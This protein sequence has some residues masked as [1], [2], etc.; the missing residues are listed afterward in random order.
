VPSP[1]QTET[2][3]LSRQLEPAGDEEAAPPQAIAC[4]YKE[5]GV[6]RGDRGEGAAAEARKRQRR[7][8]T[9]GADHDQSARIPQ[10][11][12]EVEARPHHRCRRRS[13]RAEDV[14]ERV[15][16]IG[17]DHAGRDCPLD[18]AAVHHDDVAGRV[19]SFGARCHDHCV[20]DH[21]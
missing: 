4:C 3:L 10:Q 20:P 2:S 16:L 14:P 11:V 18:V 19:T 1:N 13:L 6:H 9:H 5:N 7:E 15:R 21:P 8:Q 12:H 17:L